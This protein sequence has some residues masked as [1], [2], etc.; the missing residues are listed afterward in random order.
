[1]NP[2]HDHGQHR[3]ASLSS[4]TQILLL[5]LFATALAVLAFA[6]ASVVLV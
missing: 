1:M 2:D 6:A 4:G 5:V 3:P